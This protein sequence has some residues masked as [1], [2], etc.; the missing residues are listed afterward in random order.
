MKKETLSD[1]IGRV[2]DELVEAAALPAKVR[3]ARLRRWAALA[4]CL[5]LV[6]AGISLLPRM[7]GSTSSAPG[8]DPG[9]S[10]GDSGAAAGGG[11]AFYYAPILPLTA[12]KGGDALCVSR[13]VTLDFAQGAS[14]VEVSDRYVLKNETQQDAVVTLYY[15]FGGQLCEL[16]EQRPQLSVDGRTQD[17]LLHIDGYTGSFEAG[18]DSQGNRL[19]QL[20]SWEAYETLLSAGDYPEHALTQHV[21]L[22]GIPVVVYRFENAWGAQECRGIRAD[23]TLDYDASVVLSY[24]FEG[25]RYDQEA[26]EMSR[27]FHLRQTQEETLHCLIVVGE[28]IEQLSIQGYGSGGPDSAQT[29]EA[30]VDVVRYETDLDTVLREVFDRMYQERADDCFWPEDGD[31]ETWYRLYCDYLSAYGL[32][33][34]DV[35]NRYREGR[36]EETDFDALDRI[37]YLETQVTVPAGGEVT[38]EYTMQK[39]GSHR[40][41]NASAGDAPTVYGYELATQLGS[42]L[43]FE[44]RTARLLNTDSVVIDAQSFGFDPENGVT[45]VELE[46]GVSR[47]Y[48]NVQDKE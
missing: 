14:R 23:F 25:G 45:Q 15:P 33:S 8:G 48:L 37:F 22:S 5:L 12:G 28:D 18:E 41:F 4:A 7:G 44:C 21:D 6:G 32:L 29:V 27:S 38:L 31:R 9:V 47:Y 26:G 46:P 1:A 30:G 35:A 40:V 36:L 17:T 19:K 11:I 10:G 20:D 2:D 42:V 16:E 24:G 34:C 13:D 43:S 39:Q 3:P